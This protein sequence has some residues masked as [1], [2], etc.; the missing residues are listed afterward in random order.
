MLLG[1]S[2]DCVH[3]FWSLTLKNYK[4]DVMA[5][6]YENKRVHSISQFSTV[7]VS[8]KFGVSRGEF[9]KKEYVLPPSPQTITSGS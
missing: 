9:I 6:M 1:L 8:L 5:F 3:H 2:S 4:P 7:G